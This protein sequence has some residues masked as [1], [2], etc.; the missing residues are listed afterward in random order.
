MLLPPGV[1]PD[2][3]HVAT[4]VDSGMR[5]LSVAPRPAPMQYASHVEVHEPDAEV[6]PALALARLFGA[7]L[8][9]TDHA[10]TGASSAVSR[11]RCADRPT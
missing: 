11:D 10:A 2:E 3:L 1:S 5:R 7:E 4:L 9:V 8:L 6:T